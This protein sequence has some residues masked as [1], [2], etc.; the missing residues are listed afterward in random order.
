MVQVE[1]E[2]SP[3][4]AELTQ[5]DSPTSRAGTAGT[6]SKQ[7]PTMDEVCPDARKTQPEGAT[8]D[9]AASGPPIP[10][11]AAGSNVGL[12]GTAPVDLEPI[13]LDDSI[14][15]LMPGEVDNFAGGNMDF[16]AA[17]LED[18]GE[19]IAQHIAET[20]N[21]EAKKVHPGQDY[22]ELE[23]GVD[24]LNLGDSDSNLE[25]PPKEEGTPAVTTAPAGTPAREPALVSGEVEMEERGGAS[26]RPARAAD[27]REE[28]PDKGHRSFPVQDWSAG[29]ATGLS[30]GQESRCSIHHGEAPG[31]HRAGPAG[32]H[33]PVSP[34][35]RQREAADAGNGTPGLQSR[36]RQPRL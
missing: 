5:A 2:P 1:V 27:R 32:S 12:Q 36:H 16:T 9:A 29:V 3:A 28:D 8:P 14:L 31:I 11:T 21:P 10:P 33:R 18:D 25:E 24:G 19:E 23:L 13:E 20:Y 30:V 6:T 7:P 15:D 22:P 4:V 26:P 34:Q 17:L 35:H